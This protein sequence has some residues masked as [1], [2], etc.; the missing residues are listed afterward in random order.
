[1]TIDDSLSLSIGDRARARFAL[2]R[3]SQ[4]LATMKARQSAKIRELE[5]ALTA[6]GVIG[7]DA[8]ARALGLSRST[9]WTLLKGNHKGSGL[10]MS[11]ISRI[12]NAPDLPPLVKA[13]V[14]EY[15]QEK[16][17][18]YYG[19]AEPV[20]RRFV[21]RL[22]PALVKRSGLTAIFEPQASKRNRAA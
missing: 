13:K 11:V 6:A 3:E 10:S 21:M 5:G 2:A 19:H 22:P 9:M 17:L 1:M 4:S 18:G 12:F 20:R 16:A 15:V 8:K 7:L 14:I